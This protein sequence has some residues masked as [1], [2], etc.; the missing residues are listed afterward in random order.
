MMEMEH[1]YRSR[2]H[3]VHNE[4]KRRLVGDKKPPNVDLKFLPQD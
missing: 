4:V 3:E 1:K 2:L